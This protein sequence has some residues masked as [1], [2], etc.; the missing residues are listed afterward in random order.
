MSGMDAQSLRELVDQGL[1][2]EGFLARNPTPALVVDPLGVS[3]GGGVETPSSSLPKHTPRD[4]H[5]GDGELSGGTEVLGPLQSAQQ[6]ARMASALI[7]VN[8]TVY[9][10]R[11]SDR[12]PF[13]SLITVGRA[14]NNDVVINH[15]TVSKV[16]VIFTH[17]AETWF[18]ADDTSANGTFLNGAKL[19]PKEKIAI[20]DGDRV[21]LGPDVVARFF[22]PSSLWDYAQLAAGAGL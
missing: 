2:L 5:A 14:P 4:V 17:P 9:W 21:R 8:A 6:L 11:K 1:T 15:T 3:R 13:G 16:H 22:L 18:I 20:S 19:T 7:D 12:N 10:L